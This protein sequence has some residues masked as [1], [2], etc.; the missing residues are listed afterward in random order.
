MNEQLKVII[1][2]EIDK[3]KQNINKAKEDVKG[4]SD[5]VE[6]AKKD[7]SEKFKDIGESIKTGVTAGAAAIVA[8]GAALVALGASTEEYRNN[9]A[10]LVTAFEAAGGAASTAKDTYNDLYRVLGDGGQATEAA[11]HLA[12]LTTNEK[13]LSQWTN[14]CKGVYATFGDSLPIEGLTEAA[15][16]TAKVGTVTGSLADALNWAG[17]SEDDFNAKL[18]AC[19]SEAERE[20]LIRETLNGLY[21]DA[22]NKYEE[23]NKEVLAQNEAQARLQETTAE[24]G[25]TIAPVITAFTNFANQALAAVA[26]YIQSLAEKY[27]PKLQE[28]LQKAGDSIGKVLKFV[29]ENWGIITAIAGVIGGIV[30]AIG[31]YNVV[32]GIKA[33][34]AAMEVTT[35]WGL[36]SA[37][38]AQAVAMMAA[39]APYLLIVAAIAAVIAIVVLCVKHWD[40]IKAA[41]ER[42]AAA[43]WD[44]LK[45]AI[46]A[47]KQFLEPVIEWVK[48]AWAE[49]VE[50]FT[51]AWEAIKAVWDFVAPY[52]AL[53]WDSIKL[54]FS[55]VVEV[56]KGYFSIAWEA[57]KGVWNVVVEY[58]KL[59]WEN[60]KVVFSVVKDVLLSYFLM[61]WENIKVVWNV[62]VSYFMAI[63]DS[64][65]LIFSVVKDVFTG[66]FKG[67][68]ESVKQIFATWAGF[69]SGLWNGVKQIFGNVGTFF[70]DSFSSAWNGVK[71]VFSNFGTFFTNIWNTIKN[72]F[73]NVGSAIAN[74][75]S[76]TVKSAVNAILGTAANAIN[77][78]INAIN[79]A[80]SV[81]NL[82][83]NVNIKKL[84]K[85]NVP[86][87][88]RGGI[89]DSATLAVV[90]EQGKEAV[91]P[92]ENNLEWL[93]KLA[94]RIA[95][96]QGG[97]KPIYLMVDKRV[98]GQVSAEG[99]NDITALTGSIPLVIA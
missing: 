49:V 37:Y 75:I 82:I 53:I 21:S 43:I 86:K 89:I 16:E 65:K 3:L 97:S 4:F 13:D 55:V 26:P 52:F 98:L 79:L 56:L 19:N 33:A 42:V 23:N 78:F 14:I 90:G 59:I 68:W 24:L 60:I 81:I 6:E 11:A 38:A 27:T 12:K 76:G 71:Q 66:N 94:D 69:F 84:S 17:I 9:Q 77:G 34:M 99:I 8:A 61:A 32:A 47:I 67:A 92:L 87:L 72:T 50:M 88:A 44:F 25:K 29:T 63:W 46:D 7:V 93:D 54:I 1:S 62:A 15:N 35:V 2:A 36:V 20:K 45:P 39:I 74:A 30:A 64:I 80:I 18:E 58:F 83:P 70:K 57:I 91:V 10:K 73:K 40:T 41:I 48:M 5:K 95:A 85:L 96:R 28:A 31:L 22:A 51:L